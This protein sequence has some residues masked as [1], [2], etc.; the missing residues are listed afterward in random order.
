MKLGK[1][2]G[3]VQG[4]VEAD[5]FYP[6]WAH[7]AEVVMAQGDKWGSSYLVKAES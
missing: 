4:F 7:E 6:L 3:A 5:E 2:L 1:Y